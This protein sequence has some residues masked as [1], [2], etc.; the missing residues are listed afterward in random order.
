MSLRVILPLCLSVGVFCGESE[1]T[2]DSYQY[3]HP[4]IY[5][6]THSPPHVWYMAEFK[7]MNSHALRFL[8]RWNVKVSGITIFSKGGEA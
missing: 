2:A 4:G 1:P 8:T 7:H 3:K 6:Q 5:M